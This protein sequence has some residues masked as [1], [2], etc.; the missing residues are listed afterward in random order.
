MQ[1]VLEQAGNPAP[2]TTFEDGILFL[3]AA[4]GQR[5]L[6]VTILFSL[7]RRHEEAEACGQS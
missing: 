6:L 7:S 4:E 5:G 1:S 2:E 3:P